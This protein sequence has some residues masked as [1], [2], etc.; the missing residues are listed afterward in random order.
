M[1]MG[2]VLV[3]G[4]VVAG[5][6]L[7][8][9][10][11][12][13]RRRRAEPMGRLVMGLAL[14]AGIGLAMQAWRQGA[15]PDPAGSGWSTA[16]VGAA[17]AHLVAALIIAAAMHVLL[18][19]PDGRLMSRAH[20]RLV[21]AGYVVA[22][23]LG[24]LVIA[25]DDAAAAD[26]A[27]SI[28]RWPFV[29]LALVYAAVAFPAA[30]TRYRASSALDRRRLQWVGWGIAVAGEIVL[31]TMALNLLADW[32]HQVA[33]V[34]LGAT[35]LVA[36]ALVAGTDPR[37]AGRVDRLLTHSVALAGLTVLVVAGYGVVLLGL[38]RRPDDGERGMLLLSMVAAGVIAMA[39]PWAR[40]R[41]E[42]GA[43]RLV[44]GERVAPD[45]T[46]R[47]FGSRLTRAIPM[48]ELLL[49][50]AESLRKTMLLRSAE[51]WTG[52]DGRYELAVGVPH[53]TAAPVVVGERELP[54]VAR[55]G[56][57]GGTWVEIW[58][59]ALL[60]PDESNGRD[61]QT[62]RVAPIAHT[63]KL[64]GLI[65]LERRADGEPFDDEGDRVL[66]EL[67]RQ[68]GLALHNVQLDS[69]LQASLEELQ[70]RNVELRDSR[71]RIV[72]AGDAER[73]K[74]ERNLHDGA[75]QHLVAMAV[76]LRLAHDSIE[77]GD[78][79]DAIGL[80]DELR[81][82]LTDAIAELRA[83]A[84]GIFPPLLMSG[85]LGEALP[86]A[87]T[88]AALVTSVELDGIGRYPSE[89]EA[90]VYFCCL[91][92]LQNAGKHA[93]AGASALV[94][95]WDDAGVLRFEVADDG[96]GFTPG[97]S[98]PS[99]ASAAGASVAGARRVGHGF[100]NM[101]DRLGVF[102][103]TLTVSS[104]PGAGTRITGSIPLGPS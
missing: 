53:R 49:Q 36:P 82:D 70:S 5:V 12:L 50:L 28:S 45:E 6:W 15:D 23:G 72:A 54:V 88:R 74:L 44:Y 52:A 29:A 2:A 94:R 64:L 27:E 93:G 59:P 14:L 58:I 85:G 42:D 60:A 87:A 3:V 75:Q 89:V 80:I 46:I 68:V 26:T 69:A 1:T 62:I 20:R 91:E 24:A 86:A 97:P 16:D 11:V 8:A 95:V 34:A 19:L 35:G 10:A 92:A 61:A 31:V 102:D 56:V 39:Y 32:P 78:T 103:G 25:T 83:L 67:A 104:S 43:N 81:S 76:K 84:H 7:I 100:V 96:A 99:T 51:I 30:N 4:I 65:V 73:R 57:S 38:G 9:G 101:T 71:T 37:L 90:A 63:G 18:A 41:L 22:A 48:D 98:T 40:S 55:A 47:T 77:D 13:W 33:A 17:G 21:S 66:T 79:A